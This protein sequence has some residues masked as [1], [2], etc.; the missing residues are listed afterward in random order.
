MKNYVRIY[1]SSSSSHHI[2]IIIIFVVVI[3]II[4]LKDL[5]FDPLLTCMYYKRGSPYF[6]GFPVCD[7]VPRM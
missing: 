2:I 1:K 7:R 5:I 6:P 4:T 3:I